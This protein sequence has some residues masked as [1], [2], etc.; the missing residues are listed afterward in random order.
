MLTGAPPRRLAAAVGSLTAARPPSGPSASASRS[1][2]P[3]SAPASV[4]R[5]ER[6]LRGSA[7]VVNAG[8]RA[9]IP[10]PFHAVGRLASVVAL[11]HLPAPPQAPRRRRPP[12]RPQSPPPPPQQQ[13]QQSFFQ[14]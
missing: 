2:A 5:R 9:L 14:G 1:P 12:P 13:Q 8:T 3:R 11:S 6:I 10:S 4:A 7:P